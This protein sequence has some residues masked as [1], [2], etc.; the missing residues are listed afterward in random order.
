MLAV[1]AVESHADPPD[2]TYHRDVT[3]DLPATPLVEID[4]TAATDVWCYVVEEFVP[5][6]AWATNVNEDGNWIAARR[7]VRW[8]PF[9][10]APAKI[11]SYRVA[12]LP[13]TYQVR[14]VGT[15][16]GEWTFAPGPSDVMIVL[17]DGD[18]PQP[19]ERVAAPVFI[20]P[21][22]TN[23][24]VDV[25]ITCVTANAE[26][27]YTLDGS[28][29]DTGSTLYTGALH[30]ADETLIRAR[31][32]RADWTPSV[33]SMARYVQA[34]SLPEV[35][36]ARN[37]VTNLPWAPTVQLSVTQDTGVACWS[38]E[39]CLSLGLTVSNVTASGSYNPTN[40]V[41][42]WGPFFGV[43]E[44][45]F[46]YQVGGLPGAYHVQGR[47]SVDGRGDEEH[48]PEAISVA[49]RDG[50]IPVQPERVA[51]PV[52]SPPG[53]TNLP[54]DVEISCATTNAEIR[55]TTDGTLPTESSSLYGPAV[56]LTT[57]TLLRARAFKTGMIA[58]RATV[59]RYEEVT[60]PSGLDLVRTI[61]NNNTVLP[62]VSIAA[63]PWGGAECFTVTERLPPGLTAYD[64]G[65]SG[66]WNPTNRTLKWG[67]FMGTDPQ[68]LTY[69]VS[70]LSGSYS[71]IGS[72]SLDGRGVDVTGD[73]VAI[74]DQLAIEQVA[75]PTFSPESTGVF[76]VDVTISCATVGADVRY[77]LDGT[78][79][80]LDS[81]AYAGPIHLVTITMV[82]ARAFKDWMKPS[83]IG[84]MLYGDETLDSGTV[85]E[86]TITGSGTASPSVRVDVDP[87][88][89][90]DCYSVTEILPA[91]LTPSSISGNGQFNAASRTVKWGPFCDHGTRALT[92][93]L[94]G[95]DGTYVLDGSGSFNGFDVPTQGDTVVALN[96]HLYAL[97]A[98]SNDWSFSP[99]VGLH[100]E[101]FPGVSCY[102]VEEFLPAGVT[103][104]NLNHSGIWNP[105]TLTIKWGPFLDNL[106]RDFSYVALGSNQ[107]FQTSCRISF[108]GVSMMVYGDVPVTIGLPPPSD[109]LATVG[110]EAVYLSWSSCGH[111][112]GINVYYW[113]QPGRADEQ[114]V[115]A[116]LP[117]GGL[118]TVGGLENGTNY[119]FELTA[120]D[121]NGTESVRSDMVS[122]TPSGAGGYMGAVAFDKSLYTG[123]T[124]TAVITVWDRDLNGDTGA[125]ETVEVRVW[126]DTDAAGITMTLAET[127]VNTDRFTSVG[128]GTNLS[129]TFGPSDDA[130]ESLQVREG[131]TLRVSYDDLLPAGQRLDYAQFAL[132]DSDGDGIP[133]YWE[134]ERFGGLSVANATSDWDDDGSP[135]CD[136]QVAGTDPKDPASVLQMLSVEVIEGGWVIFEW[137]SVEGKTYTLEK[138]HDLVLG[139]YPLLEGIEATPPTNTYYDVSGGEPVFYRIGVP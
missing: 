123:V 49:A 16:D 77:T 38:Y 57:R 74:V 31:G 43:G 39:E 36:A 66:E 11:L 98:V 76:P 121:L 5:A 40:R 89:S 13:G 55:Y 75:T 82:K 133:D 23:V 112:A 114:M 42:K 71:L 60:V 24:P 59:G 101:P 47:T 102:T 14:G 124:E 85:I 136:E 28:V 139:F 128:F 64:V 87:S 69:N 92:Y 22:E 105:T 53:S 52:L 134:R 79:P 4:I 107:S 132:W 25:T 29:P 65:Q 120:Y 21:G 127:S 70:G 17:D 93:D 67:P 99:E 94:G 106:A 126:S 41:I 138:S 54:V 115:D 48:P 137:S 95:T 30:F 104:T 83:D 3:N 116:G 34:E 50:D 37:V 88:D 117:P 68:T 61:T 91:G 62:S 45:S 111:E 10:N 113:T 35:Y 80:D 130:T 86:R 90:V 46:S 2:F 118:F 33:A 109:V 73:E 51:D 58:S 122:A 72:G 129:F 20:P 18:I 9:T 7:S 32:F 119:H 96:N 78:T 27:R 108:D 103:P 6:P 110:N 15:V 12:G 97:H 84:E 63:T 100:V 26:I 56:H 135:D 44:E 131:D 81:P 125:V 19:P 1:C 8:G